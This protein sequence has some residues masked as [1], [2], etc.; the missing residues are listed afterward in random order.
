MYVSS[1][2]PASNQQAAHFE[3]AYF[4][5]NYALFDSCANQKHNFQDTTNLAPE[6]SQR[7]HGYLLM[8]KHAELQSP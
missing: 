8:P 3:G 6:R 2:Q 1:A 4:K 7:T 5:R